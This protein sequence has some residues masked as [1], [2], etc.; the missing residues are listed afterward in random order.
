MGWWRSVYYV[1]GWHYPDRIEWDQ[2]QK[3]LKYLQCEQIKK[4]G[5]RLRSVHTNPVGRSRIPKKKKK[6][7]RG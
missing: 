3:H 7:K 2:R 5:V 6:R 4:G 1:M